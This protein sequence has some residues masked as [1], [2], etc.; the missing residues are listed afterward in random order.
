MIGRA[1]RS[2]FLVLLPAFGVGGALGLPALLCL[3]GAASASPSRLRQAVE[4]RPLWLVFLALF[5]GFSALSALWSA[6]AAG[7]Q[8]LKLLVLVPLG[9]LFAAAAAGDPRLTRA[10]AV[11]AFWVLAALLAIEAIWRLPLNS[12]A[13]PGGDFDELTRNVARGSSLCLALIWPAA[14]ALAARPGLPWKAGALA[15]LAAGGF[16]SL[17]FGQSANTLAFG[18]GLIAF[19]AAYAAPRITLGAL[20]AGLLLWLLASPFLTPLLLN[21]R[22]TLAR[23]WA[24]RRART[25]ARRARASP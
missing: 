7:P 4:K 9:L 21:P 5:V 6:H 10:G 15:T 17:Q 25:H 22:T 20:L 12:A 23:P 18:A 16:I 8:A 2:V 14:G 11:A 24:R 13:Q 3:A 19:L 1:S